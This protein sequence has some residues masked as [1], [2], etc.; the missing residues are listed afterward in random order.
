MFNL[1]YYN[2]AT[3][4]H[5]VELNIY[6]IGTDISFFKYKFN[7]YFF[8]FVNNNF[9]Y[10]FPFHLFN[11]NEIIMDIWKKNKYLLISFFKSNLFYNIRHLKL[12]G[13]GY[14]LYY[15]INYVILKL[16]YSH[17]CYFLLPLNIYFYSKQKKSYYKLVSFS[18]SM[19]GNLLFRMQ[20]FKIPNKYKKKGIFI[21]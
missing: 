8:I 13:R 3:V 16:G 20:C 6:L 18:S 17:L 10:F 11:V 4:F 19:M 1:C 21:A 5:Y 15:Y 12:D 2:L 14:K 7:N 9:F